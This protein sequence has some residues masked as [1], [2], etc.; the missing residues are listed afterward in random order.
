VKR[1]SFLRFI[2]SSPILMGIIVSPALNNKVPE[3]IIR[4]TD[5]ELLGWRTYYFN[6]RL[7]FIFVALV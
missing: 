6:R 7:V 3:I 1:Y 5:A 4:V 2:A